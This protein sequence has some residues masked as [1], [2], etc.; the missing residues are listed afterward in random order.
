MTLPPRTF[1]HM[2]DAPVHLTLQLPSWSCSLTSQRLGPLSNRFVLRGIRHNIC[3]R[4]L[5]LTP[6]ESEHKVGQGRT[7]SVIVPLKLSQR[8]TFA[9]QWWLPFPDVTS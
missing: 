9:H 4:P 5:S 2:D 8:F 1:T 6:Q 3:V 7:T